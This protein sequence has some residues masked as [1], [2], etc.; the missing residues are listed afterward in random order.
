V[1]DGKNPETTIWSAEH[2]L[3]IVGCRVLRIS[4]GFPREKVGKGAREVHIRT[5]GEGQRRRDQQDNECLRGTLM[6]SW[7]GLLGSFDMAFCGKT[8]SLSDIN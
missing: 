2:E 5:Q 8:L 1:I 6:L 7:M 4:D 3:G